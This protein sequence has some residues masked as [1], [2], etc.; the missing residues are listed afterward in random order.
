[1]RTKTSTKISTVTNPLSDNGQA[2]EV[3]Q[4][5]EAKSKKMKRYNLIIQEDVFNQLQL[6]ADENDTT[7]LD[8]MRRFIKLGLIAMNLQ[9]TD[10]DGLVLRQN[11]KE[12]E[13]VLI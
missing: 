9:K 13:I 5:V 7:V 1:M 2:S 11:G 3:V 12:R 4:N 10:N 8:L 6:L